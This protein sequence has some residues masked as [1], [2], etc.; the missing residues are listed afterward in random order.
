MTAVGTSMPVA[1]SCDEKSD[2]AW[3]AERA[4]TRRPG[5]SCAGA[6]SGLR[7]GPFT[8]QRG[9]EILRADPRYI[10]RHDIVAIIAGHITAA[11]LWRRRPEE[12]GRWAIHNASP[13]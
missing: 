6:R 8:D 4:V 12:V 13:H 5:R 10:G 1:R 2:T 3:V 7:V 9:A 11:V